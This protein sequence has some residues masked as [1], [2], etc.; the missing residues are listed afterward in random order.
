ME[1]EERRSSAPTVTDLFVETLIDK[2]NGG[3]RVLK[4]IGRS[5]HDEASSMICVSC[6]RPLPQWQLGL[7]SCSRAAA[8]KQ[9][10]SEQRTNPLL[11]GR[12]YTIFETLN[13]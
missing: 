12:G 5:I 6:L 10:S 11:N 4:C 7:I 2:L 8:I 1:I 13:N 9:R 3:H